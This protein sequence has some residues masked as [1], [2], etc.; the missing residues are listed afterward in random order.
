MFIAILTFGFDSSLFANVDE[1][2]LRVFQWKN[3]RWENLGGTASL[4][5]RTITVYA[6]SLSHFAVA[7]VPVPGAVWLFGSGLFGLGLLRKRTAVA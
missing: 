5:D 3:N 2:L 7:A 4:D 6:D 1:S